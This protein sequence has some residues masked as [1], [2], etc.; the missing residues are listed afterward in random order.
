MYDLRNGFF[1]CMRPAN[2]PG[3]SREFLVL[4]SFYNLSLGSKDTV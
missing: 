3:I 4:N 1:T 2:S